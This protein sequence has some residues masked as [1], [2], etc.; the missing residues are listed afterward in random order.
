[1]RRKLEAR[2]RRRIDP[3]EVPR[4]TPGSELH[5]DPGT[6]QPMLQVEDV[7]PVKG[8]AGAEQSERF[9]M[10]VSDGAHSL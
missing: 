2:R 9:R 5:K 7:W 4:K 1:M 6:I 3:M 10:L 8:A